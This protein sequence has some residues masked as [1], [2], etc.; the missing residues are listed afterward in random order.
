MLR[1]V[2]SQCCSCAVAESMPSFNQL[3]GLADHLIPV[4]QF[5]ATGVHERPNYYSSQQKRFWEKSKQL[6]MNICDASLKSLPKLEYQPIFLQVISVLKVI[7]KPKYLSR[8][9]SGFQVL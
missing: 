2:V 9:Y 5:F 1:L 8:K 6:V 4:F 7:F 3:L